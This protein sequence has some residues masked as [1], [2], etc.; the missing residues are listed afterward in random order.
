ML[1]L[2]RV[3][4]FGVVFVF[5]AA[6]A[7]A[8]TP[9]QT[10]H[11]HFIVQAPPNVTTPISGRLLLFLKAGSGDKEVDSN[12]MNPSATW[13]GAREGHGLSAGASVDVDPDAEGIASPAPFAAIPTGDYEVQ[14]V[15]D[16]GHTYNYGGRSPE[17]WISPVVVLPHWTAGEGA[18]PVLQLS[19]HPEENAGTAALRQ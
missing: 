1:K 14:A 16:V 4:Q 12:Q 8:Q 3:G 5:A 10:R 15:L 7:F 9:A 13:V 18:E 11:V 19:G 2:H 6:F 17:D